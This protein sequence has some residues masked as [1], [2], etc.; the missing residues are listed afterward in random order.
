MDKSFLQDQ[1]RIWNV[2]QLVFEYWWVLEA[3]RVAGGGSQV[4]VKAVEGSQA[5]VK[6]VEGTEAVEST[7][8]GMEVEAVLEADMEVEADL[9]AGIEAAG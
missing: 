4:V 5:V 1:D 9:E 2:L 3:E 8:A 6:A 7:V